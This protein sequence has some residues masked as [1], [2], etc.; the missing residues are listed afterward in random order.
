MPLSRRS[1]ANPSAA[2]RPLVTVRPPVTALG[3]ALALTV[4]LAACAGSPAAQR[5]EQETGSTSGTSAGTSSQP[6]GAAE[7]GE[8]RE[9]T[10]A[11]D[12]TPNTNHSGVYLAQE[13]GYFEDAG[14][15]VQ[16]VEPGDIGGLDL[17][18]AGEAD[19]A[20]SFAESLAPAV[21]Q[22]VDAVSVAAVIDHNTSSLIFENSSG[23][24]SPRD[25]E[26][27]V[28]GTYGS[29]LE[30]ALVDALVACDGGDPSKVETAPLASQDVRI[31]LTQDQYDFVWVY[32]AW[33]TIRLQ[34]L[35]GMDVGTLPF[36]DHTECIPDWYTPLIAAQG[37]D[38]ANDPEFVADVVGALAHGYRDAM[39]EPDAAADALMAAAPELDE[40]LVRLSAE[41]L[42]TRYAE[43]PEVWGEQEAERW[44]G[45]INF[46][47]ENDIE[48]G[49]VD[50]AA[51]W[52]NDALEAGR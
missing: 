33:D 2:A 24:A 50:P 44:E 23:I 37:A 34:E 39:T 25:L 30:A 42:S 16:I 18:A 17:L 36:I 13:R 27:K 45:F 3:V 8:L 28:Y 20:Y 11:L 14:L 29:P 10:I 47:A 52:T 15:D 31:G 49:D 5:A 19:F 48:G 6:G 4:S 41:Y 51:L 46:L 38:V 40:D 21:A 32:D 7:S 12:Y 1:V 22:G 26:G 9:V 43:T 35:D